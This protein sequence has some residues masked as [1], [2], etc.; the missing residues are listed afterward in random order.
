MKDN[1]LRRIIGE[2]AKSRRT[3]LNLTHPYLADMRGV[4]ASTIQRY[5]ARTIDNT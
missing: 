2:R 4:T 3:A 1:E 5:E